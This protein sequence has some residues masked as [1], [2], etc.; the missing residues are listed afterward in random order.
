MC[1]N[2]DCIKIHWTPEDRNIGSCLLVSG[3]WL[4]SHIGSC[5]SFHTLNGRSPMQIPKTNWKNLSLICNHLGVNVKHVHKYV[6]WSVTWGANVAR[7]TWTRVISY[8]STMDAW[9]IAHRCKQNKGMYTTSIITHH[10]NY[11]LCSL[12]V[13]HVNRL[14][15]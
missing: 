8:T 1:S 11:I 15:T 6:T 13:M 9:R 5:R 2:L 12:E 7:R 4:H 3:R 14:G 10:R